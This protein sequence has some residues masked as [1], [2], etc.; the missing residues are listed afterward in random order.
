MKKRNDRN[1]II[2]AIRRAG[3][4]LAEDKGNHVYLLIAQGEKLYSYERRV[5]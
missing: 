3:F 4:Y 2:E 5:K 1:K